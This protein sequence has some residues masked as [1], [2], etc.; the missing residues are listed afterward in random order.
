MRHNKGQEVSFGLEGVRME[1]LTTIKSQPFEVVRFVIEPSCG[2]P[3]KHSH[4]I[5]HEYITRIEQAAE[6]YPG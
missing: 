4:K 6:G 5:G 2:D 1:V 3:K